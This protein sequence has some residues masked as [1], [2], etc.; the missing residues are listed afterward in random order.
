[1]DSGSG[2]NR[3]GTKAPSQRRKEAMKTLAVV[4]LL[5]VSLAAQDQPKPTQCGM[6]DG[7]ETV[8]SEV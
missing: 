8:G 1:L 6:S 7:S 5:A 3:D 2:V 4:L